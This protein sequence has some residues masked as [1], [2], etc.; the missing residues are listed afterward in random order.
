[1]GE[2]DR[3][4]GAVAGCEESTARDI[5]ESFHRRTSLLTMRI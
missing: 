1:M 2:H 3:R 4:A 5:H